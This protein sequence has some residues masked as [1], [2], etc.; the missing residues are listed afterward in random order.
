M[1]DWSTL[2]VLH[3]EMSNCKTLYAIDGAINHM[4][5]GKSFIQ[6]GIS[7]INAKGRDAMPNN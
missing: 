1:Y 7:N 6:S 4:T 2:Q 5:K 3:S